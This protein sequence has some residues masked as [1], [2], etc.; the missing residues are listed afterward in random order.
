MAAA[1]TLDTHCRD[2]FTEAIITVVEYS[3]GAVETGGNF[4]GRG[5]VAG[6]AAPSTGEPVQQQILPLAIGVVVSQPLVW[7]TLA[8]A[9]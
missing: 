8:D 4:I 1:W 9:E 7:R 5:R 3:L 2:L 6:G